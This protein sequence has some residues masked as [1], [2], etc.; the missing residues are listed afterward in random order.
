M[1]SQHLRV[2]L[3]GLIKAWALVWVDS[4]IIWGSIY[5]ISPG[6]ADMSSYQPQFENPGNK[7]LKFS[8]LQHCWQPVSWGLSSPHLPQPQSLTLSYQP[9]PNFFPF[10][11]PILPHRQV[12]KGLPRCPYSVGSQA[13]QMT[14]HC[15]GGG[16][17]RTLGGGGH[18]V[19]SC[20]TVYRP[21]HI[22]FH[23][24][25]GHILKARFLTFLLQISN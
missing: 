13:V 18:T 1:S 4:F 9:N 3:G 14:H 7:Q 21:D 20:H 24:I 2:T 19:S 5:G 12:T 6:N 25:S 11:L 23:K 10:S 8:A 17:S 15:V 22:H 16:W